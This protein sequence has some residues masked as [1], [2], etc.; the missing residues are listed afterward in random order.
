MGHTLVLVIDS[1]GTV[2]MVLGRT[3][4][5]FVLTSGSDHTATRRAIDEHTLRLNENV[6]FNYFNCE[7]LLCSLKNKG[8]DTYSSGWL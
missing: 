6:T 8:L 5:S 1:K 2:N 7:F 4:N 3:G